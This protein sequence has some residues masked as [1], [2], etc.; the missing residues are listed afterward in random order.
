MFD[1]IHKTHLRVGHG[2]RNILYRKIDE[3]YAN[4]TRNWVMS[5][6]ELCIICE[7]KKKLPKKGL[8]IKSLQFKESNVRGQAHLIDMQSCPDGEFKFILDYQ[9]HLSK[10]CI[11]RPLKAKTADEVAYNS[12]D[13]P[14]YKSIAV[15]SHLAHWCWAESN[16]LGPILRAECTWSGPSPNFFGKTHLA[17]LQCAKCTW[18]GQS[19]LGP[20]IG[21]GP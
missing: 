5:Y 9:D 15:Q 17:K 16:L 14:W 19:A 2:G 21:L 6:L 7:K 12:I 4:I 11:L 10:F 13:R 3:N 18:S 1:I 8:T 20:N